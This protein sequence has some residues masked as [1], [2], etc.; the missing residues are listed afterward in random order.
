MLHY[1]FIIKYHFISVYGYFG[2]GQIR[3]YPSNP[4]P[5]L[6]SDLKHLN[7]DFVLIPLDWRLAWM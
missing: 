2:W 6:D 5:E 4:Y 1:T 3:I 7:L